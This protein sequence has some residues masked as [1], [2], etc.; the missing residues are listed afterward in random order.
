MPNIIPGMV[1]Q[2]ELNRDF[3]SVRAT[4]PEGRTE[5]M[6]YILDQCHG[7]V[8]TLCSV[9]RGGSGVGWGDDL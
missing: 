9:G 1:V 4:L 7:P 2:D 8:R 6:Q 5:R 3:H